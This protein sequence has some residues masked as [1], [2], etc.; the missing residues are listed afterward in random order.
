MIRYLWEM[1]DCSAVRDEHNYLLFS[2]GYS[3]HKVPYKQNG[4]TSDGSR[5]LY[6]PGNTSDGSLVHYVPGNT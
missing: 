6:L 4:D 2:R 5:V 1:Y 3:I